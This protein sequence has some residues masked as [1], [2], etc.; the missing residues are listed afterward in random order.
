M[1]LRN[2]RDL[3]KRQHTATET[4]RQNR[5]W[6]RFKRVPVPSGNLTEQLTV[7]SILT[8][9]AIPVLPVTALHTRS[10]YATVTGLP[11]FAV[12]PISAVRD[13]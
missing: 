4:T 5:A 1:R 9:Y 12:D 10:A 6:M 11:A 3:A 2:E 7:I 8:G 13:E